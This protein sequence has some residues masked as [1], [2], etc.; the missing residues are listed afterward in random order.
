MGKYHGWPGDEKTD[1][2]DMN[3]SYVN[4]QPECQAVKQNLCT[5][6][7]VIHCVNLVTGPS[8]DACGNFPCMCLAS[9]PI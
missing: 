7:G 1:D 6:N 9:L 4:C 2:M 3:I 5:P 8:I